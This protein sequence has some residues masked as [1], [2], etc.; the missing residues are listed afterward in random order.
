MRS[1]DKRLVGDALGTLADPTA[2]ALC[3]TSEGCFC[4]G[5]ARVV[6]TFA[7]ADVSGPSDLNGDGERPSMFEATADTCG[8]GAD[9][10]VNPCSDNGGVLLTGDIGRLEMDDALKTSLCADDAFAEV[11]TLP[12]LES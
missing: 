2:C 1:G 8:G 9:S 6:P 11:P 4:T 12:A 5:A 3:G 7:Q 10:S